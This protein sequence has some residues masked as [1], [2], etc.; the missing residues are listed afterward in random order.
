MLTQIKSQNQRQEL[1]TKVGWTVN[2]WCRDTSLGRTLAYELLKNNEINSVKVG[3]RTIIV[4][5][6]AEF[7]SKSAKTE[8]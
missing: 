1:S 7:L 2:E 4:T 5:S 3:S 8:E 6:P